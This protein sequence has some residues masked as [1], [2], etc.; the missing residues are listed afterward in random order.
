MLVNLSHHSPLLRPS[1][2]LLHLH[3]Q[4]LPSYLDPPGPHTRA[5]EEEEGRGGSKGRV[6]GP[7]PTIIC[8]DTRFA[9]SLLPPKTPSKPLPQ[10]PPYHGNSSG[11]YLRKAP[12]HRNMSFHNAFPLPVSSHNANST[13]PGETSRIHT[14]YGYDPRYL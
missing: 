14:T 8:S 12:H 13:D 2:H 11:L 10:T 9:P 3:L 7:Y 4:P 6:R 1:S 5:C